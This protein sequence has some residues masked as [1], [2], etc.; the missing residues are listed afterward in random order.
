MRAGVKT[1]AVFS[2][3]AETSGLQ[4][5]RF[6]SA[7]VA[8]RPK[9]G[10]RCS[11]LG[12]LCSDTFSGNSPLRDWREIGLRVVGWIGLKLLGEHM[13]CRRKHQGRSVGGRHL[14]HFT[15]HGYPR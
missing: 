12:W 1:T 7:Q 10:Q 4:Q 14:D 11:P 5:Y 6:S 3:A 8:G 13:R 15:L 9:D 2:C